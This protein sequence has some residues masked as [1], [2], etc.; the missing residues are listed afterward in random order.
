MISQ[1]RQS[2]LKNSIANFDNGSMKTITSVTAPPQD[3][4]PI[5]PKP[6]CS[7]K[8]NT[9]VNVSKM[10]HVIFIGKA[11]LFDRSVGVAQQSSWSPEE[12]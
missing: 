10:K 11:T 5:M 6:P 9:Y 3:L 4:R 1:D 7:G 12:P 2:G 8:V